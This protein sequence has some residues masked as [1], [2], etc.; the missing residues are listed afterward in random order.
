[1]ALESPIAWQPIE[2]AL[3]D[4][5]SGATGITVIWTN[6]DRPEPPFPYVTLK[7]LSGPTSAAPV[8]ELVEKTNLDNDPG[9]EI[10]QSWY[11]DDEF[12]VSCQCRTGSD[13]PG[14]NAQHYLESAAAALQ[15]LTVRDAIRSA[16]AV[17]VE[18]ESVLDLD[19]IVGASW[20]SGASLDVRFRVL[21]TVTEKTGYIDT[22][23][24]EA[25]F[26]PS[27]S[28]SEDISGAVEE[29]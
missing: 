28:Y 7:R 8:A 12:F 3:Y 1:M 16:G 27:G 10:E 9:E 17:I 25:T 14:Q 23:G 26:L 20:T 29:E 15:K 6:Q 5:M 22:I 18:P 24:V 2:D 21:A 19:A 4:W 11:S 13:S